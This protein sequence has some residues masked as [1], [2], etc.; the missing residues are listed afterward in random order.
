MRSCRR[1]W[2]RVH[3]IDTVACSEASLLF[4]T[5]AM[6]F[7]S[8]I[9]HTGCERT[10]SQPTIGRG[11]FCIFRAGMLVSAAQRIM[12]RPTPLGLAPT[13]VGYLAMRLAVLYPVLVFT[14]SPRP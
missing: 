9:W 3:I 11:V 12:L 6:P 14:I 5:L 4:A 10:V 8:A 1:S 2:A 13:M 7:A